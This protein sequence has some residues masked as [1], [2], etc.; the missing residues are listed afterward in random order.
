MVSWEGGVRTRMCWHAI[1]RMQV[2]GK[3]AML[4]TRC[5]IGTY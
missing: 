1:M 2:V 5:C 3:V 4:T